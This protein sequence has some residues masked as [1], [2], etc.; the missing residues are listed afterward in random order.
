M[1]IKAWT[2]LEVIEIKRAISEYSTSFVKDLEHVISIHLLVSPTIQGSK[3]TG[4]THTN[5]NSFTRLKKLHILKEGL[6]HTNSGEYHFRSQSYSI[7][8]QSEISRNQ[9]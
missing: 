2:Y 5:D 8:N 7:M 9:K 3:K 4:V 1:R 6:I